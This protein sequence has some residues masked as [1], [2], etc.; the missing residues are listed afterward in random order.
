LTKYIHDGLERKVIPFLYGIVNVPTFR[1]FFETQIEIVF[2]D[3]APKRQLP[4]VSKSREILIAKQDGHVRIRLTFKKGP[5]QDV[6]VVNARA[7][8][9]ALE[10]V[11]ER[12]VRLKIKRGHLAPGRYVHALSGLGQKYNYCFGRDEFRDGVCKSSEHTMPLDPSG[13]VFS[14]GPYNLGLEFLRS[15]QAPSPRGTHD[16][17]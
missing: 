17:Y 12:L 16:Y 6:S 10:K 2:C 13:P 3:V 9:L 1:G 4:D 7:P 11:L 14:P 15:F 8:R 5:G